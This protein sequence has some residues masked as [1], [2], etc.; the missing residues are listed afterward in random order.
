MK[1][2]EVTKRE[3]E[4][5]REWEKVNNHVGSLS[6][7]IQK[8]KNILNSLGNTRIEARESESEAQ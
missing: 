5:L 8:V 4:G 3:A 6:E 1:K 2:G 7:K